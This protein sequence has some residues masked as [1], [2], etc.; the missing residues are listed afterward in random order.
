MDS[1]PEIRGS[2]KDPVIIELS[3]QL[4]RLSLILGPSITTSPTQQRDPL[5]RIL[6]DSLE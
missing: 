3:R 4:V 6:E 5:A 2:Q 1:L